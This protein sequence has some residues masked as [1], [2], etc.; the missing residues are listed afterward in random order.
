[1]AGLF[2]YARNSSESSDE[3][4]FLA[5][6]DEVVNNFLS[7]V[8][9]VGVG[10]ADVIVVKGDVGMTDTSILVCFFIEWMLGESCICICLTESGEAPLFI[11]S[12]PKKKFVN[13]QLLGGNLIF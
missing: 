4:S 1:M 5:P 9:V 3:E 7:P 12:V 6:A 13:I 11:V 10:E 2:L 8:E